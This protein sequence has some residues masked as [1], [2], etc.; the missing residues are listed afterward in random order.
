MECPIRVIILVHEGT[1][2]STELKC[3]KD[4]PHENHRFVGPT[5]SIAVV[6]EM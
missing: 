2:R 3:V 6:E 5:Y 4:R 1:Q